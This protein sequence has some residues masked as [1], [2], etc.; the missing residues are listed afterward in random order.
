MQN[1]KILGLVVMAS[2]IAGVTF[3]QSTEIKAAE[4]EIKGVVI[5][6]N[7]NL[8]IRKDADLDSEI[9]GLL[10]NGNEVSIT[11]VNGDWY[12]IKYKESKGYVSKDYIKVLEENIE[13]I[14]E[15]EKAENVQ[16]A[17]K[18]DAETEDVQEA[19]KDDTET[20]NVQEVVKEDTKTEDLQEV[21]KEEVEEKDAHEEVK[22]EEKTE[23]EAKELAKSVSVGEYEIST[24]ALSATST[25]QKGTVVN[26]H[27]VLRVR[28]EASLNSQVVGYL[29][30]GCSVNILGENGAWYNIDYNGKS[31]Y[32]SKD[33]V[34]V[35]GES[36]SASNSRSG[37][38]ETRSGKSGQV[39]NVH[40]NLN[41]RSGA[42]TSSNVIGSLSNGSKVTIVGESGS[43]Y[44]INYGNTTGY[45]SKDYISLGATSSKPST[46]NNSENS[47]VTSSTYEIVY[48]AMVQ[49][50]G[51]PYVWGG[52][53]E[54]LTTSY[55]RTMMSI[56]P[57]QAAAG[58]YDRALQYADQG[59]RAFDC[60]GL[61]QWG[62]RQAGINIGRSTYD[63]IFNGTEVSIY[64]VKPGD[65]LFY[66]NLEH[67]G[68]YVGNDMWIEAPNSSSNVRIVNVPWSKIGRAR[69]IIN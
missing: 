20:E 45:V 9:I 63:Q 26:V 60:S 54:L 4:N 61:M 11:N 28:S 13:T 59:Y 43:W 55:V 36:N 32:V 10:L 65:L 51:S 38:Q 19:I 7:S 5:N 47:N 3:V 49:H 64:N 6:V 66:S 37:S 44:K 14:K 69:R 8:A 23:N 41:V 39:V 48:N 57:S 34:Q 1:K 16:E 15:I 50:L 46:G 67:V 31:V 62:Y 58:R 24:V 40:S 52:A 27:S 53:G 30:N 29:T 25:S 56:Y 42:S 22:E 35:S 21:V 33:Y 68:M 12:E 2:T 18:D 17:V